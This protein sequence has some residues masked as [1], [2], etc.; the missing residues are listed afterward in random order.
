MNNIDNPNTQRSL[1]LWIIASHNHKGKAWRQALMKKKKAALE[2]LEAQKVI[3]AAE[4][5][6]AEHL[7]RA[8]IGHLPSKS[9]CIGDP[10]HC[11]WTLSC[12]CF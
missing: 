7:P 2:M 4:A 3:E 9:Y 6:A 10:L 12:R 8:M 11:G 5:E 1:V